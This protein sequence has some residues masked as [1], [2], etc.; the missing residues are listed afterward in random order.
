M[1]KEEI[2]SEKT[3]WV[4]RTRQVCSLGLASQPLYPNATRWGQPY[5][6]REVVIGEW[7]GWRP[8]MCSRVTW[9]G[10][11]HVAHPSVRGLMTH[12][13][14]KDWGRERNEPGRGNAMQCLLLYC[15]VEAAGFL[16]KDR[17]DEVDSQALHLPHWNLFW[18]RDYSLP[19]PSFWLADLFKGTSSYQGARVPAMELEVWGRDSWTPAVS[20]VSKVLITQ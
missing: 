14:R 2:A 16:A 12:D 19:W 17:K 7:E 13:K 8:E 3:S 1:E 10:A 11:K 6:A 5:E 4:A 20:R 18:A 15:Q 9:I